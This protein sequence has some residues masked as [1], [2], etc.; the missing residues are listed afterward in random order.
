MPMKGTV[1]VKD[2]WRNMVQQRSG[3]YQGNKAYSISLTGP[4]LAAGTLD[5]VIFVAS[6]SMDRYN[7]LEI[8]SIEVEATATNSIITVDVWETATI[9]AT[10]TAVPVVAVNR[11]GAP[12]AARF[13]TADTAGTYSTGSATHLIDCALHNKWKNDDGWTF[14]S[15]TTTAENILIRVVSSGASTLSIKVRVVEKYIQEYDYDILGQ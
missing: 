1:V 8:D 10:D 6:D 12:T 4:V 7:V 3:R 14:S 5:L 15:N 9:T 13:T 2:H 11:I